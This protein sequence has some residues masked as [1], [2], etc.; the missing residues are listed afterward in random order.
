YRSP[1]PTGFPADPSVPEP[2]G[3]TEAGRL[4]GRSSVLRTEPGTAP[5]EH[6][7]VVDGG[8]E[9]ELPA[10]AA[11]GNTQQCARQDRGREPRI[12]FTQVARMRV[13]CACDFSCHEPQSAQPMQ[14]GPVE[15]VAACQLRI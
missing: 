6:E 10:G 7:S 4:I 9:H 8:V 3:C 13:R 1:T 11:N 12:Q 15:A 2:I 14:N 5:L